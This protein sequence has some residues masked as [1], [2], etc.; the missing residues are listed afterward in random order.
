MA[1]VNGMYVATHK[2][3]DHVGNMLNVVE[4]SDGIR[5]AGTFRPAPWLPVKFFDKH[6]EDWMVVLGGKILACD[7]AG[8]LVPAQYGLAS[9]TI[10]YTASDV[11]AGVLDVRTGAPLLIGAIGTFDVSAVTSFMGSGVAMAVGAPIGVAMY[12][13]WKW[14]G[15]NSA[16]D[17]GF[18]PL[19]YQKHN[20]N[21]QHAVT[22]LCDSVLELPL[23]P[24]TTAAANLTYASYASNKVTF[25]AV[26]NRPVATNTMRTPITFGAGTQSDQA[27]RFK[28]QKATAAEVDALGDWHIDL[29]TGVVTVYSAT[30]LGAGNLYTVTYSHYA[31]APATVSAFAC[32]VGNLKA[33]DFVKCDANS[34]FALADAVG[35]GRGTSGFEGADGIGTIIGQVIQVENVLNKSA[36]GMV[37]TAY[38]PAINTSSTGALPGYAGQ[39]DQM[40]GSATGGVPAKVHAAGAADKV[41]RVN[42]ISR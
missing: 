1:I 16:L 17:D 41:V 5:P 30:D 22:F 29:T 14:A 15:D 23:V 27:V 7:N 4:F 20:Y 3:W 33:G 36:L 31:S 39:L 26:A 18:N 42:L 6:Y 25:A 34:N 21:M 12:P 38:S 24:A 2:P 19:G 37:R 28:T 10:T 40:P 13:Y 11:T 8:W 9:A 35:T 32:A